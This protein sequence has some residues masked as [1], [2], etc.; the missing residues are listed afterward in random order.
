MDVARYVHEVVTVDMPV[1]AYSICDVR[2][3]CGIADENGTIG[4]EDSLTCFYLSERFGAQIPWSSGGY[5][6]YR[7]PNKLPKNRMLQS[8]SFTAEVC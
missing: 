4:N 6:E 1:G 2:P 5:V 8:I 7:F 3:T